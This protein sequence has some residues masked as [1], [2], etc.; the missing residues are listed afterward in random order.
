MQQV[1]ILKNVQNVYRNT[2][3]VSLFLRRLWFKTQ[4]GL[5]HQKRN[6][7]Y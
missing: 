1:K 4:R 2:T 6:G 3:F 7:A 5:V